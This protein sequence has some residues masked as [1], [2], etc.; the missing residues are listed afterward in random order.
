MAAAA[1]L[2][3]LAELAEE[4]EE[5]AALVSPDDSGRHLQ[6]GSDHLKRNKLEPWEQEELIMLELLQWLG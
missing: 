6:S 5:L 1:E 2:A 4:A 3:V